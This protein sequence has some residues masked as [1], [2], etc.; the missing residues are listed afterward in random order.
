M[1]RSFSFKGKVSGL[2]TYTFEELEQNGLALDGGLN[3]LPD[4]MRKML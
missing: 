1:A 4:K 2:K 3:D